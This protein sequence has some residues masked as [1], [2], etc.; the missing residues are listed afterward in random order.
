MPAFWNAPAER[1]AAGATATV[2][3]INHKPIRTALQA[4]FTQETSYCILLLVPCFRL[5]LLGSHEQDAEPFLGYAVLNYPDGTT[6]ER[7]SVALYPN[8]AGLTF[9]E[10]AAHVEAEQY[11]AQ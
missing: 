2:T 3:A 4:V 8:I 9:S 6:S 11:R 1:L 10:I 7:P 5:L